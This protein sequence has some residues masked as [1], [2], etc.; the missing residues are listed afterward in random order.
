MIILCSTILLQC[1]SVLKYGAHLSQVFVS[2]CCSCLITQHDW[3]STRSLRHLWS[4]S[5]LSPFDP[6]NCTCLFEITSGL[7]AET[8][9]FAW[10]LLYFPIYS[11]STSYDQILSDFLLLVWGT[12]HPQ[13]SNF[14]ISTLVNFSTRTYS[15]PC[16]L[17]LKT[18]V[19]LH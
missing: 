19:I 14:C 11:L 12:K 4:L 5:L 9:I 3:S 6:S 17:K 18:F 8:L 1:V 16:W 2:G 10:F 13:I 15:C 7:A